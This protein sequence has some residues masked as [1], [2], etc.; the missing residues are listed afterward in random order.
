MATEPHRVLGVLIPAKGKEGPEAERV[1]R[2]LKILANS[3]SYGIF[4]EINRQTAGE[5]K[6]KVQI[7]APMVTFPETVDR[8]EEP[9]PYFFP[10]LAALT[11]AGARL[12]LAMLERAVSDI[13]GAFAFCDTDSMAIVSTEAG[14]LVPCPGGPRQAND[15][16]EAV[17]ALTWDQVR[18]IV[19]RFESLNPYGFS[20]SVLE[21]EEENFRDG[22]QRE[23]WALATPAKRY[24]L[25]LHLGNGE[26]GFAKAPSEHGLGHLLDPI[27]DDSENWYLETWRQLRGV[28]LEG[29]DFGGDWLLLPAVS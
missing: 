27:Q 22:Q 18:E 10:P 11:T 28:E 29:K 26:V 16:R 20:G 15:G 17:L 2:F 8:P 6:K 14:G 23:L 24:A 13:G 4:A 7:V 5:K 19:R 12:M 25:F 3:G 21:I 1:S 9:G